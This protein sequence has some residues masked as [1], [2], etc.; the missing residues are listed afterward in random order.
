M[1]LWKGRPWG[2]ARDKP[3]C[4]LI[5]RY[6]QPLLENLAPQTSL[7]DLSLEAFLHS[8]TYELELIKGNT[9]EDIHIIG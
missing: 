6:C 4:D 2:K 7:H 5:Y 1:E 8:P 9:T 3:V